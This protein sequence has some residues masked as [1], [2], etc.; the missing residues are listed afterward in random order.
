MGFTFGGSFVF[1]SLLWKRGA[2]FLGR[3]L[4]AFLGLLAV[5]VPLSTFGDS[6]LLVVLLIFRMLEFLDQVRIVSTF[7]GS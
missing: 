5:V 4:L 2:V 1:A 6:G 7:S 3:A